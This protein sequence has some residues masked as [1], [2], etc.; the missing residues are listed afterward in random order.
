MKSQPI[1]VVKLGG[2]VITR[3]LELTTADESAVGRLAQEV[4]QAEPAN[5]IV[6]HGGG[7]F[8]H[9]LA[10]R[11]GLK[12][13][14]IENGQLLGFARTHLAMTKLN[15]LVIESLV[16]E[17]LPA[18]S[19]RPSAFIVTEEGRIKAES[20]RPLRSLL[21]TGFIPVLCGDV[22]ADSRLGFTVLS[23]DQLCVRLAL[24]LESERLVLGVDVDGLF[25]GDPKTD[26]TARMLK[27][28]GLAE[29][30][31]MLQQTQS[32]SAVDV[33]GGMMGKIRELLP[34]IEKGGV[35]FVANASKPG[36]LRK[37]LKGEEFYGTVICRG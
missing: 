27:A 13:G 24:E 9:P 4:K 30:K 1:L 29:I 28:V 16:A 3:K 2:S 26:I 18:V 25:S 12:G 6:V 7:S 11:Y 10:K 35:V 19:L 14:L 21:R 36:R 22:V 5:L 33:T 23:G 17:G 32:G 15:T 34:F 20:L 8:G 37:A 31:H